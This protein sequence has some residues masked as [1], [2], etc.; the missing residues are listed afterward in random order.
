MEAS[1]AIALLSAEPGQLLAGLLFASLRTGAALALLPALGGQ[2]IP[3]RLR[4]GLA[5]A[6]GLLVAGGTAPPTPPAD[7][8]SLSGMLMIAGEILIGAV[9]ALALHAAFAAARLAGEWVAQTM[10]L[11]FAMQV[12]PGAPPQPLL[13]GLF[14][15]VTWAVFLES[16]GHILFIQLIVESHVAMPTA[17]ALLQPARLWAVTGWAGFAIAS[18]LIAALPL[19]GGL[20]LAN[21]AIGVAARSAPQLNL[22]AVGFP[23]MLLAGLA[24]LPLAFPGLVESLSSALADMQAASRAL[25][26]GTA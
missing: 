8:L 19:G 12:A 3:L 26:L 4:I 5:G 23:L 17:A 14:A 16:G 1:A 9:A 15:L 21:I 10:G 24:G 25:L 7:L 18:G 6:V 11:G 22:F 2:M 20:L 13:S